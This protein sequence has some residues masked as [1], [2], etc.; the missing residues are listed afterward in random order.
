MDDDV[1]AQLQRLLQHRGGKCVVGH[2]AALVLMAYFGKPGQIDAPHSWIGRS[3]QEEHSRLAS[4]VTMSIPDVLIWNEPR[5]DSA[6]RQHLLEKL[7]R[8]AVDVEHGD[9]LVA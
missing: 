3:L 4:E 6:A 7:Q 2:H 1:G 5:L 8:P 9:D